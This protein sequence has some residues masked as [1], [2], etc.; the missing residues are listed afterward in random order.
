MPRR[1]TTQQETEK[2]GELVE[3]YERQNKTIFEIAP[4]LHINPYTV[5]WRIIRLKIPT[6]TEREGK[7]SHNARVLHVPEPSGDL[8]E[9]CGVMLGDGHIGAAQI[10][11]TVNI[12]TDSPYVAYLQDL[13]ER[14]FHFR[15]RVTAVKHGSTVDLYITSA[16]LVRE[17]RGIGLSSSNKV[18]DQVGVPEW[19]FSGPECQRRFLRGF[20]DTDGSIYRLKHFDAVQM[21]FSNLSR[22][23][24]E[25]TRRLLLIPG[26]HPSKMSGHS[27]YLTRR[28][29]VA[30]YIREI[31][32]GNLKHAMR[33]QTFRV[34]PSSE[35]KVET[36]LPSDER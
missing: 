14:L 25:G 2:H 4:I 22:P 23:L 11:I 35:E 33:A 16:Y 19:I 5:Y 31:G 9:F 18:R 13:L 28:R 15:P 29:D 3:L 34:L 36:P 24:L 10:S 32:F 30:N 27:V 17:L 7:T 20:F 26:Y 6:R 1:W 12:K 8:A 21:S